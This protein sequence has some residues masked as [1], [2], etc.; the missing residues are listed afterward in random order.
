MTSIIKIPLNYYCRITFHIRWVRF[1]ELKLRYTLISLFQDMFKF[2]LVMVI[3]ESFPDTDRSKSNLS[4]WIKLPQFWS[5]MSNLRVHKKPKEMQIALFIFK[6][7]I[8][9]IHS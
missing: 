5:K 4:E 6:T 1:S 9:I 2:Y 7:I 3:D 8:N